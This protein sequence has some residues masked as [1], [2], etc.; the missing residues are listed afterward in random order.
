MIHRAVVERDGPGVRVR[1]HPE[2]VESEF[3]TCT[4][5]WFRPNNLRVGPDGA[6]YVIDMYRE[7][8]EDYSAIPRYMQQQYGLLNGNDK[9]RIWRVAPVSSCLLYTSPSPRDS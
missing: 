3:L 5:G 9:G 7:I 4:D 6:L 1:R 8:I 2:H